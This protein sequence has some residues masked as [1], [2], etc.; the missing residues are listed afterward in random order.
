MTR[1]LLPNGLRVLVRPGPPPGVVAVS[2]HCAAGFRADPPDRPGLAHLVEHL[3][4]RGRGLPAAARPRGTVESLGGTAGATT[5]PDY[6]D[7]FATAPA[8][9]LPELL[10]AEAT[11]MAGLGT[12]EPHLAAE[13]RTVL[14]ERASRVDGRPYGGFPWLGMAAL[15]HDRPATTHDG[16]GRAGELARVTADDCHA[17][18]ARHHGPQRSVLTVAGDVD[19]DETLDRVGALFGGLPATGTARAADRPPE[20]PLP[21]DRMARECAAGVPLPALAVGRRV[22]DP[23][24]APGAY[25]AHVLLAAALADP[26]AAR[27]TPAGAAQ[28][29]ARVGLMGAAWDVRDPDALV[30]TVLHRP[31]ADRAALLAGVEAVLADVAGGTVPAA[32]LASVAARWSTARLREADQLLVRTRRTGARELL[33]G[34]GADAGPDLAAAVDEVPAAAAALL[35]SPRAVLE[36]DPAAA[37]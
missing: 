9:A 18:A 2:V 27:L 11:R 13:R 20:P 6:T 32:E 16:Y 25:A 5:H 8:A 35:A 31:G 36:L 15:L 14:A 12:I 17:F 10:A 28:V 26:L 7:F 24:A 3:A 22:P 29:S 21:A 37:R 34:P 33:F 30:V 23:V 4:L 1:T 19:P